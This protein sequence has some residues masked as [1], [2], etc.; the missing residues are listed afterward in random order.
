MG[1]IMKICPK[2]YA[3]S[4]KIEPYLGQICVGQSSPKPKGGPLDEKN[5]FFQKS[6]HISARIGSKDHKFFAD[7]KNI[8]INGTH[9]RN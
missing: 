7:S 4:C 2:D 3:L 6:S 1:Q 8:H 9:L 5:I